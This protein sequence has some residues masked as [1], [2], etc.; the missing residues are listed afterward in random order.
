MPS[1][2]SPSLPSL[3]SVL[4]RFCC[5]A[6]MDKDRIDGDGICATGRVARLKYE[7]QQFVGEPFIDPDEGDHCAT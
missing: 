2:P 5:G 4:R 7:D 3:T 6:Q 1:A